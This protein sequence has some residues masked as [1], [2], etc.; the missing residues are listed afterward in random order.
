MANAA[1]VNNEHNLLVVTA[2]Q[3]IARLVDEGMP[4]LDEILK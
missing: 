4:F 1:A 2:A 3:N